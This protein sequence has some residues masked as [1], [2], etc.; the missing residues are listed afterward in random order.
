MTTDEAFTRAS[1]LLDK[2]NRIWK[3]EDKP[4]YLE[5]EKAYQEAV[6]I[7]DQYFTDKNVL[8]E[9]ADVLESHQ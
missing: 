5:A 2:A 3:T 9:N 1:R 4:K 6:R 7:R 8:T